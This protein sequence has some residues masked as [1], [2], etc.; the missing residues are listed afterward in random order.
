MRVDEMTFEKFPEAVAYLINEVAQIKELVESNQNP[1]PTKRVPIGIEEACQIIGKV[2]P[3][4]PFMP[5]FASSSF[6]PTKTARNSISS[7]MNWWNGFP[8]VNGKRFWK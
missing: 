1:V 4:R 8:T 6:S 2:K 3:N 7:K 5:L